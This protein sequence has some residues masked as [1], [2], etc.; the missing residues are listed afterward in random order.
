MV[1]FPACVCDTATFGFGVQQTADLA[2][3]QQCAKCVVYLTAL[4]WRSGERSAQFADEVRMAMDAEIPLL[5]V[6]EMPGVGGQEARH[7]CE[8]GTFFGHPEGATPGDLLRRGIYS[9]IAVALKGAEW[10]D[11]SMVLLAQALSVGG[12]DETD[13]DEA[14]IAELMLTQMTTSVVKTFER[15]SRQLAETGKRAAIAIEAAATQAEVANETSID[16][17]EEERRIETRWRV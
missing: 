1:W 3:L 15:A 9:T 10:R 14:A 7:G 11:A 17:D 8:F 16:D 5:L 2:Q 12:V 4:T 13:L 6:H